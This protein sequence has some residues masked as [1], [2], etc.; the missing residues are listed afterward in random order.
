MSFVQQQESEILEKIFYETLLSALDFRRCDLLDNRWL[1]DKSKLRR[2]H[3]AHQENVCAR[4]WFCACALDRLFLFMLSSDLRTRRCV[5]TRPL[6][7]WSTMCWR[8]FNET[9][10]RYRYQPVEIAR[11]AFAAA[12]FLTSFPHRQVPLMSIRIS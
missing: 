9:A 8:G 11:V 10:I 12:D 6:D 4:T 7:E 5:S 2:L 1:T 3:E